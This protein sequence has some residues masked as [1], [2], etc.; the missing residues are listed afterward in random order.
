MNSIPSTSNAPAHRRLRTLAPIIVLIALCL[1]LSLVQPIRAQQNDPA[2]A[3]PAWDEQAVTAITIQENDTSQRWNFGWHPAGGPILLV[4]IYMGDSRN[5]R[6]SVVGADSGQWTAETHRHA[7]SKY[8]TYN[9]AQLAY[10]GNGYDHEEQPQFSL[11]VRATNTF[12]GAYSDH[13]LTVTVSDVAEPPNAPGQPSLTPRTGARLLAQWRKPVNTGPA[14]SSYQADW[15]AEEGE[16]QDEAD[17]A[18][19][20]KPRALRKVMRNLPRGVPITVRVRAVNDEGAS[21]WSQEATLHPLKATGRPYSFNLAENAAPL[22][23]LGH[24]QVSRNGVSEGL[25]Y[26]LDA[27]RELFRVGEDGGVRY[28]G[29]G[30]D[31]ESLDGQQHRYELDVRVTENGQD[32]KGRPMRTGHMRVTVMVNITDVPEVP[33]ASAPPGFRQPGRTAV[34]YYWHSADIAFVGADAVT[35]YDF[36]FRPAGGD[37]TAFSW[38]VEEAREAEYTGELTGLTADTTYQMQVRAVNATGPG[39]WSEYGEFTTPPENE[40]PT[41]A[42]PIADRNETIVREGAGYRPH[43]L[44]IPLSGV[45]NDPE[46]TDMEVRVSSSNLD[47]VSVVNMPRG[48]V[49]EDVADLQLRVKKPGT[50]VITMVATDED[51][52]TGQENGESVTTTFTITVSEATQP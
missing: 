2:L 31:Y 38:T 14:I 24:I 49:Y 5:V 7:A 11:T 16:W 51:P 52:H 44:R 45:F 36:E 28:T 35:S 42:N 21:P 17:Y 6:Y 46:D 47:V 34:E 40:P 25:T 43:T 29:E 1:A 12:S 8:F 48:P 41:V 33:G 4:E 19:Q 15:K 26:E 13:V 3:A 10:S 23:A 32:L 39:P 18:V 22:E 27:D 20:N 9:Y 30:E 50:A 37:N